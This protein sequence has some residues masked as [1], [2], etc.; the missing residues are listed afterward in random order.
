MVYCSARATANSDDA[1]AIPLDLRRS[2]SLERLLQHPLLGLKIF[3]PHFLSEN[4]DFL[5]QYTEHVVR[6]LTS[7]SSARYLNSPW[8]L[9]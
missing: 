9:I 7:S 3:A 8:I 5:L 1:I 6:K 4:A 2:L